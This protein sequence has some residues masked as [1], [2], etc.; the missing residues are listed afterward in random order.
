MA[1]FEV[2]TGR[3]E[4]EH[5][6]KPV[7]RRFW[8]FTLVSPMATAK[9]HFLNLDD[10]QRTYDAALTKAREVAELRKSARIIVEP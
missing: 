6:H 2:Y 7:G 3:Y 1:E 9:D 5:G 4:R 10:Q 8:C